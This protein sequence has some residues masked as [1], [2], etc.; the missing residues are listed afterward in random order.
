MGE[1]GGVGGLLSHLFAAF[2]EDL[3]KLG[4]KPTCLR[5][6]EWRF[7]S[8][9]GLALRRRVRQT[10][11]QTRTSKAIELSNPTVFVFL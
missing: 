4:R 10:D 11:R 9:D 5:E 7:I 8:K 6:R 3:H 1:A 2:V